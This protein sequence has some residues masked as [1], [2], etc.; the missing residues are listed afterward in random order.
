MAIFNQPSHK[1]RNQYFAEKIKLIEKVNGNLEVVEVSLEKLFDGHLPIYHRSST[2][3]GATQSPTS[4]SS[5]CKTKRANPVPASNHG[6]KEKCPLYFVVFWIPQS[7]SHLHNIA[8]SDKVSL[9]VQDN[10]ALVPHCPVTLFTAQRTGGVSTFRRLQGIMS[11][12]IIS[13]MNILLFLPWLLAGTGFALFIS[14]TD[15]V[16]V[17]DSVTPRDEISSS[18]VEERLYMDKCPL[19]S[20]SSDTSTASKFPLPFR[21]T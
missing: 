3:R 2:A 21:R 20:F 12:V 9:V 19:K 16:L 5:V 10:P 8:S 6:K 13:F 18:P 14:H 1:K 7:T 15:D 11:L 17:G 4:T